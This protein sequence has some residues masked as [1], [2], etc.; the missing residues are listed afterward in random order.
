VTLTG[1]VYQGNLYKLIQYLYILKP[2]IFLKTQ[3]DI[4]K[5]KKQHKQVI[6]VC[7]MS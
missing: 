5:L 3:A 7:S 4:I 6:T 2:K 1:F